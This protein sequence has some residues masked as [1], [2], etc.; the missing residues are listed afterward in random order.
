MAHELATFNAGLPD[1]VIAAIS[2]YRPNRAIK[3]ATHGKACGEKLLANFLE[4]FR[5]QSFAGCVSTDVTSIRSSALTRCAPRSAISALP[6]SRIRSRGI[7][8]LK[9]GVEILSI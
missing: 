1:A 7:R 5:L 2:Q 9:N 8:I 4:L 6:L 3:I